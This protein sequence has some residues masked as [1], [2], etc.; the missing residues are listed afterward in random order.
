MHKI[1][2]VWDSVQRRSQPRSTPRCSAAPSGDTRPATKGDGALQS[3]VGELL[4]H[5]LTATCL[6]VFQD[7]QMTG[8]ALS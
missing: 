3:T 7:Q 2:A 8:T 4:L 1:R 6:Q 5:M